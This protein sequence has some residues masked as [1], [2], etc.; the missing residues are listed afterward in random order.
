[1]PRKLAAVLTAL[2]T[3]PRLIPPTDWLLG[4]VEA[5]AYQEFRVGSP[6]LD[7]LIAHEAIHPHNALHTFGGINSVLTRTSARL[8][9]PESSIPQLIH[10]I[11]PT[12]LF[13]WTS[14]LVPSRP[15]SPT[16]RQSHLKSLTDSVTC[17][18]LTPARTCHTRSGWGAFAIHAAKR[19]GVHVTGIT[20]SPPQVERARWARRGGGRRR[21]RRLPPRRLPRPR[22]RVLRRRRL[23]R[24]GR[25]RRRRADGRV[26]A[27][28]ARRAAPG[29]ARCCCTGSPTCSRRTRG[30]A[31]SPRAT[32]SPTARRSRSR[33]C[34]S[35]SSARAS[36]RTTS[37]AS[38]TT[39]PRRCATGR[40][41]LD[42]NV[43]DA[44][45]AR[46]RR[47]RARAGGCTC[48]RPA[49][50]SRP[51]SRRS[52]RSA[53][54]DRRG[55]RPRSP[56]RGGRERASRGVGAQRWRGRSRP[57]GLRPL[58]GQAVPGARRRCAPGCRSASASAPTI[59]PI[60]APRTAAATPTS[61]A[62][63]SCCARRAARR[64]TSGAG[65]PSRATRRRRRAPRRR[66]RPE[67]VR[68]NCSGK[69]AFAI[70]LAVAEGW[71]VA[72]YYG[73]GHPVQ[74]AMCRGVAEATGVEAGELA[75]AIDGCGMQTF[76]ACRWRGSRT[77]SDGSPAA[78]SGRRAR[79]WRRR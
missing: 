3:D 17:W 65:R 11:P 7:R 18:W 42:D 5:K 64:P 58:G 72:G 26:R 27:A 61:C 38:A 51:A 24:D 6:F 2:Q 49:T 36:R 70:A 8:Y 45:P 22:R 31:R 48:A 39:T 32:C 69:H 9:T 79:G 52:I 59:S 44:D 1:M 53:R 46:G 71:P 35:G 20:V 50:A 63:A 15:C 73:A 16:S 66:R 47:A 75:Q 62:C 30:R 10:T 13:H 4:Q 78:V 33:A 19:H 28:A 74:V 41:S 67:P 12:A 55:R 21:P 76:V 37:R 40:A 14:A 56:R 57:A 23:D 25:A 34:C 77:P 29:R 54:R 60:A 43:D 68:H